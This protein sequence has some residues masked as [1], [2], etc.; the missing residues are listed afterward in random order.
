M[1][2]PLSACWSHSS[3]NSR[4]TASIGVSFQMEFPLSRPDSLMGCATITPTENR[5][6]L[7][8]ANMVVTKIDFSENGQLANVLPGART[9][10]FIC[11]VVTDPPTRVSMLDRFQTFVWGVRAFSPDV[12]GSAWSGTRT[13]ASRAVSVNFDTF[14]TDIGW[15]NVSRI[16]INTRLVW[17]L[18]CGPV[19]EQKR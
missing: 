13:S 6:K 15:V 12:V 9:Y 17:W 18:R 10:N 5:T 4:T 7:V 3:R 1:Q 11:D 2:A 19:K 16:I 14:G 8:T